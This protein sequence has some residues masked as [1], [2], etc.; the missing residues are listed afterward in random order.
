MVKCADPQTVFS[1]LANET[2]RSILEALRGGPRSITDLA[3]PFDMS[4]VA[5]SKH[6][7]ILEEADLLR[8]RRGGRSRICHLDPEPLLDA[9]QWISRIA[10]FW[11]DELNQ[12]ERH[13]QASPP[14]P[15]LEKP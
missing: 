13:L 14:G 11:D 1:A 4:L 12:I 5:V 7:H 9:V 3:E 2:R 10:D 15:T 6:V 8:I